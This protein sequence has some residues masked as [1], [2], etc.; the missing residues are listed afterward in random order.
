MIAE[1]VLLWGFLA[2]LVLTGL[3]SAS[4]E[5][6]FSRMAIPFML[7]TM[8]TADR[9]RAFALGF[10]AHIMM[11]WLFALGY[12]LVFASL[13]QGGVALGVGLG[14]FHGLLVLVAAMPILPGIHPRMASEHH[15]PEPTRDLE[16]PGFLALNYGPRTPV[17]ALLAHGLY[18]A[19]LGA[20]YPM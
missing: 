10:V 15:G 17:V 4:Q 8:F 2:T 9:G 5:L 11:G 16:P 12:A 1:F 20:A 14:L 6:G 7:G 18:G 19:V 13:G 3:M